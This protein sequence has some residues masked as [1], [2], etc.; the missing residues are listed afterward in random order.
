MNAIM[1]V[2]IPPRDGQQLAEQATKA[3]RSD[4][5]PRSVNLNN[6]NQE[7]TAPTQKPPPFWTWFIENPRNCG[8]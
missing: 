2:F 8:V 4:V 5:V 6:G 1:V 3:G 7:I